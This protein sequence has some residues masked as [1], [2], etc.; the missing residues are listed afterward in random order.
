MNKLFVKERDVEELLGLLKR[1]GT[2]TMKMQVSSNGS[3]L[4]TM[5]S[6]RV[7]FTV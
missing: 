4:G 6:T 1:A 3:N 5:V 7:C 2:T